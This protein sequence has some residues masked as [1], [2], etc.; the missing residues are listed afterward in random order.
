M[1]AA[2]AFG[3]Y[4]T[5][6]GCEKAFGAFRAFPGCQTAGLE[7]RKKSF[8]APWPARQETVALLFANFWPSMEKGFDYVGLMA[9]AAALAFGRFGRFRAAKHKVMES[10]KRAFGR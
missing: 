6:P 5:F 3:P 9:M 10:K 8:R 4:R 7:R 1:A 2:L